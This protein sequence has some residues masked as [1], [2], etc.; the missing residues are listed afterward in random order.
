MIPRNIFFS[1]IQMPKAFI[2]ALSIINLTNISNLFAETSD[3]RFLSID[4]APFSIGNPMVSQEFLTTITPSILT[5]EAQNQFPLVIKQTLKAKNGDTLATIL[6]RAGVKQNDIYQ[7]I[8]KLKTFFDPK[9]IRRG[10]E[11]FVFFK[12]TGG[13]EPLKRIALGAFLGFGLYSD[14]ETLL[15]IDKTALGD[16][17]IKKTKR[18]FKTLLSGVEGIIDTNLY[19]AG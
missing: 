16:F 1:F 15:Q 13:N 5:N 14:S 11:I 2:L 17:T 7:S 6:S 12:T 8:L 9:K 10:Q 19:K 4:L 3:S 18:K